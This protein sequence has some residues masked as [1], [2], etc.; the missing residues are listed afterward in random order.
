MV[1]KAK[2]AK[3]GSKASK[4]KPKPKDQALPGMEDSVIKPIEDA[5]AEYADVRDERMQ[6]TE[7][8]TALKAKL[9][10]LMHQHGKAVYKRGD[11]EVRVVPQDET[12]KV[13]VKKA[14]E[15]ED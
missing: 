2:A 1:R 5:A 4:V 6:L 14:R 9:L 15:D 7:S 13:R 12:I 10:K 11:I 3:R 8:E